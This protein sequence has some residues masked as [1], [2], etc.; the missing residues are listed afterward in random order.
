MI[1][2]GFRNVAD[3]RRHP[4]PGDTLKCQ[5]WSVDVIS[6]ERA[7]PNDLALSRS[8]WGYVYNLCN[9]LPLFGRSACTADPTQK[10]LTVGNL[11]R[12]SDGEKTTN[13]GTLDL[14][15]GNIHK[16]VSCYCRRRF[17]VGLL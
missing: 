16:E 11:E 1:L 4:E 8:S 6:L 12:K 9:L 5:L 10:T 17:V 7:Q 14:F 3:F 15:E 13:K 2:F